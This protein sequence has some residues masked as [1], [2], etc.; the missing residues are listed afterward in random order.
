M[1]RPTYRCLHTREIGAQ[2][3]NIELP[4]LL[5]D[6]EITKALDNIPSRL[7]LEGMGVYRCIGGSKRD[8]YT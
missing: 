5:E 8:H 7:P 6:E 1:R 3:R 2:N 4:G